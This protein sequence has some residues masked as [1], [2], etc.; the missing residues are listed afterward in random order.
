MCRIWWARSPKCTDQ[1]CSNALA[2]TPHGVNFRIDEL[3]HGTHLH[4]PGR[5]DEEVLKALTPGFPQL[6]GGNAPWITKSLV[7]FECKSTLNNPGSGRSGEGFIAITPDG[8]RYTLDHMIVK[9]TSSVQKSWLAQGGGGGGTQFPVSRVRVWLMVTRIEDRFG[10]RVNYT[11][12]DDRLTG[13]QS[14]GVGTTDDNRTLTIEYTA[15]QVSSIVSSGV[16]S[17][18]VSYAYQPASG[19]PALHT[20]T[21]PDTS[22]WVYQYAAGSLITQPGGL[23]LVET[24]DV[25]PEPSTA[26]GEFTYV[27]THPSKLFGT[28]SFVARRNYR[29][30]LDRVCTSEGNGAYQVL[31]F[32]NYSDNFALVSKSFT[33][34]AQPQETWTYN[35]GSVPNFV[36][37]TGCS[38]QKTVTVTEPDGSTLENDFGVLAVDFDPNPPV[39]LRANEGRLLAERT[40]SPSS[41][42]LTSKSYSYPEETESPV[43]DPYPD[44]YGE[45]FIDNVDLTSVRVRP[46]LS[47]TTTQQGVTFTHSQS[48]FDGYARA[49]THTKSSNGTPAFS[50]TEAI[51]FHDDLDIWVLHQEASRSVD[52]I[53]VHSTGFDQ[54]TARPISVSEY[55]R[56]DR[57]MTWHSD[58][59]LHQMRDALNRAF[60]LTNY[61]RG[62]AKSIQLPSGPTTT[63][64]VDGFGNLTRITDVMG[65]ITNYKYDGRNRLERI[66]Y[67]APDSVAWA[68]T[69]ILTAPSTVGA[70][71]IPAGLWK[72]TETTGS[73]VQETWFDG[74][75]RPILTKESA[76]DG[77]TTPTFIRRAFDH[78]NREVFVSYPAQSPVVGEIDNWQNLNTGIATDFDALDRVTQTRQQSEIGL[79]TTNTI[80]D[81]GFETFFTDARGFVTRTRFQA[82]DS[83]TN[84]W[85]REI[86]AAL[87]QPIAQTTEITRDVFGKPERIR[88]SG[89][90]IPPSGAPQPQQLDRHF[91]YDANQRLCKTVEPE[92]G[93]TLI[94]YDS[95]N[96]IAWTA[97]GQ[98]TSLQCDRNSALTTQRSFHTYDAMHRLTGINHPDGTTDLGYTYFADGAV[99]TASNSDPATPANSNTWTYTYNKRRLLE[100]ESLAYN[101][102]T[103]N[104]AHAYN[105]LAHR[106][107]L[108]YPSGQTVAFQPDARGR[109][110]QVGSYVSN[111]TRHPNGALH[112]STYANG[113][114]HTT[115]QNLRMLPLRRIHGAHMNQ[116]F[117]YDANAN[118]TSIDDVVDVGFGGTQVFLEDRTLSYDALNRL[119]GADAPFQYGAESYRYDALDNLRETRFGSGVGQT[120]FDYTLDSRNLTSGVTLNGAPYLSYS[121]NAQGDALSRVYASNAELFANGFEQFS[122]QNRANAFRNPQFAPNQQYSFD[123]AHRL[124]A[125]ANLEAYVYDAHGRRIASILPNAQRRYQVYSHAGALLHSEDQSTG[126][127]TDYLLLDNEL[128]AERRAPIGGGPAVIAYRHSDTRQTPSVKTDATG[129][130]TARDILA[131]F[132]SPY[133]GSYTQGPG[134][135]N[136]TTDGQSGLTYMQQRYYDPIGG[137]FLSPDPMAVDPGTAW[138]YNRYNYAAGNPYKYRDADGQAA[139]TVWDAASL[140]AGGA[141]FVGNVTVGNYGAAAVDL[142]GIVLDGAA[143]AVPGIPGG[144]GAAIAAVRYGDDMVAAATSATNGADGLADLAKFRSELGMP[145]GNGTLARLDV[146]G[147]SFYGINAHDQNVSLTV[148]PISRT[149]AETDALQ[150]AANSGVSA[151]EATLFVD[152]PLCDACGKYGA[153]RSMAGQLGLE[154]ITVITPSG[155][156]VL[157][158]KLK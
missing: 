98:N 74:R 103:F 78:R 36:P 92:T 87:G 61:E 53:S 60:T 22:T 24:P 42:L 5:G 51:T 38:F 124:T 35:Y 142:A 50:K 72:R 121:H 122:A 86:V 10:N 108:T 77:S 1:R 100:S 105:A 89:N 63:A 116:W 119:I 149:H 46:L 4:I 73:K 15:G 34:P 3:W 12:T 37:C 107:S 97:I 118:L 96:Q 115:F 99:H 133:S 82:Y 23:T 69:I 41:A 30:V 62:V 17:R 106:Q 155:T 111:I 65:F 90:Y 150:Q 9:P 19:G 25:C 129:T 126:Q 158:P 83:P 47:T 32:P 2:P 64:T 48:N 148:N 95:V 138:N 67:P 94:D 157:E 139:E 59:N 40:R 134:F 68:P 54:N 31:R 136:H 128:V 71:G 104:I 144:A 43:N 131:P 132:G 27:I 154:R 91:I 20:V 88:R 156:T 101:N 85:P 56:L 26:K 140:A 57:T 11:W 130:R 151:R 125:I 45:T 79:L 113:I 21:L 84:A 44:R 117:A 109:A 146:D 70:H 145:D 66:D 135:T 75:W 49:R 33:G 29:V 110:R 76:S 7:R 141:A 39:I 55:G 112:Q 80:Y 137:R 120:V 28:F 14:D 147:K 8:V 153:V 114:A 93:G 152:R 102:R 143:T 16:P 18:T 13:I 52:G 6:T 58:G 123:R 127:T 81:L